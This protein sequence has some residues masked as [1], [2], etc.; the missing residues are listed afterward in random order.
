[1]TSV[2]TFVPEGFVDGATHPMVSPQLTARVNRT[3]PRAGPQRIA[4]VVKSEA[5]QAAKDL[6]AQNP[7]WTAKQKFPQVYELLMPAEEIARLTA[8]TDLFDWLDVS[9]RLYG[10]KA[11]DPA[12]QVVFTLYATDTKGAREAVAASGGHVAGQAGDGTMKGTIAAGRLA[13]LLKARGID[14]VEVTGNA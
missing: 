5:T 12:A 13:D 3:G 1:M 9:T 4:A 10:V 2:E 8:R 11:T 7:M 14:A 6:F